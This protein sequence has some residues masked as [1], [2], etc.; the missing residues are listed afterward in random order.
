MK[1]LSVCVSGV[2]IFS[3]E[4][5]V[6][7]GNICSGPS[8]LVDRALFG[9][10]PGSVGTGHRVS[11]A[12]Y[13]RMPYFT[14]KVQSCPLLIFFLPLRRAIVAGLHSGFSISVFLWC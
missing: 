10:T 7:F 8:D 13:L 11:K 9:S 14:Q 12:Y 5:A 2:A 3:A 4:C 1:F 6:S